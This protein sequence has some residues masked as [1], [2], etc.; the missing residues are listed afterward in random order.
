MFQ[1]YNILFSLIP[2]SLV[3]LD[4]I[5]T[6]TTI[7]LWHEL[8]VEK[9]MAH[10]FQ[11]L[12]RPNT[13]ND[14]FFVGAVIH[15]EIRAIAKCKRDDMTSNSIEKIAYAPEYDAIGDV[16]IQEL[17]KNKYQIMKSMPKEQPRW[18]IAHMYYKE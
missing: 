1:L 11:D 6:R 17:V 9:K 16:F 5:S 10:D 7:R 8:Y 4:K 13:L 2:V 18:Y 3:H 15:D 12:L 14:N